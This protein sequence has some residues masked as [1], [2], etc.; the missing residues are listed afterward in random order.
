MPV[1]NG[2]LDKA[3][4]VLRR[5]PVTVC[6]VITGCLAFNLRL[7]PGI[8]DIGKEY[9]WPAMISFIALS[10]ALWSIGA[11]RLA[12]RNWRARQVN[13]LALAGLLLPLIFLV[14]ND[15]PSLDE[16]L[17]AY[18]LFIAGLFL[19]SHLL[20]YLF[21]EKRNSNGWLTDTK[22]NRHTGT[23]ALG[24]M[25]LACG[26]FILIGAIKDFSSVYKPIRQ[27]YAGLTIFFGGLICS[28]FWLSGIPETD[29]V[30]EEKTKAGLIRLLIIAFFGLHSLA[31][32]FSSIHNLLNSPAA[33]KSNSLFSFWLFNSQARLNFQVIAGGF[34]GLICY[35][36][37]WRDYYSRKKEIPH[38]WR[39]LPLL[40]IIPLAW[41][42][43]RL[44]G[45]AAHGAITENAY[46]AIL[47]SVVLMAWTLAALN[48]SGPA[49]KMLAALAAIFLLASSFGPF[50]GV[51]VANRSHLGTLKEVLERNRLISRNEIMIPEP[52]PKLSSDD[53]K[54]LEYLA[55]YFQKT[56]RKNYLTRHLVI[57]EGEKSSSKY[58]S[59]PLK[60]FGLEDLDPKEIERKGQREKARRE[61]DEKIQRKQN[62]DKL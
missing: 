4:Y 1:Y 60:L 12:E 29:S 43:Y 11:S 46:I 22:Y 9:S 15:W 36:L 2:L 34:L 52:P 23:A 45:E 26:L 49:L 48:S 33:D 35:L 39:F 31:L 18:I 13:F 50:S 58:I 3:A 25:V 62:A 56:R 37:S 6:L 10:A 51:N 40:M 59:S 32:N 47:A 16:A 8:A 7:I 27:N 41:T 55:R 5:F 14:S 42:I 53:I 54:K 19:L 44:F 28:F 17:W 21:G 30:S 38:F 20:P 57:I 61:R 24:F